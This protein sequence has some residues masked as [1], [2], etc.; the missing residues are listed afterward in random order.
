MLNFIYLLKKL[1]IYFFV[2]FFIRPKNQNWY[3]KLI[4]PYFWTN[5][6]T[7]II[8]LNP[9]VP[10]GGHHSVLSLQVNIMC[11]YSLRSLNFQ[12][13]PWC[14]N[15]ILFHMSLALFQ[16]HPLSKVFW[17]HVKMFIILNL[18]VFI[19]AKPFPTRS[20]NTNVFFS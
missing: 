17:R 6:S 15:I 13:R 10:K 4:L 8:I 19:W 12:W 3:P 9:K 18:K 16:L 14:I 2:I 7:C 20:I 1:H 11:D 5:Y